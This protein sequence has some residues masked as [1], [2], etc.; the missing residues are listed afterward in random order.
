MNAQRVTRGG[1]SG[2]A[3]LVSYVAE[4]LGDP[5]LW[6]ILLE[7]SSQRVRQFLMQLFG[8][9]SDTIIVRHPCLLWL[10]GLVIHTSSATGGMFY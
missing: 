6:E 7:G 3:E 2:A 8:G 9:I 4:D 5:L 10:E 1:K